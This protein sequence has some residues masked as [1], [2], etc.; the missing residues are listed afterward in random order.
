[1]YQPLA[2]RR[3]VETRLYMG[4][5]THKGCGPPFAPLTDPPDQEDVAG[6]RLRVPRQAPRGRGRADRPPRPV[7]PAGQGT[8]FVTRR[9]M[10]ARGYAL[11]ALQA[12][13]GELGAGHGGRRRAKT[14]QYVTNPAAGFSL[15]FNKYGTVAATPFVP[16]DQR[17][18]GPTGL[19]FRTP[20]L[21][22]PLD[23]VGPIALHLVAK[24]TATRHRL[25]RE[26]LRCR[27]RRQRVADHRGGAARVPPRAR[28]PRARRRGRTTRMWT[29]R[30][31]E[32]ERFYEYDVEIWPTAYRL[33]K[34]HRLQLRLTSPDL[35]T[36]L[37]G[38]DRLRPR[39][40]RRTHASTSSRRRPTPCV[41]RQLSHR[42][43]RG[44]IVGGGFGT[45][46]PVAAVAGRSAQR[47]A[48]PRGIHT[49]APAAPTRAFATAR[50][51]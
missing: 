27:A 11:R 6:G 42:V 21:E 22:R 50:A 16:A 14:R 49:T 33:A 46:L 36:H 37:P 5:C 26:A 51:A 44:R 12:R 34:G 25:V 7:L 13:P 4:P 31:I 19:T 43:R 15:A 17:L 18:E 20:L 8:Q 47:G 10:A 32:P 38:L 35:P 41:S 28:P 1:M 9:P 30:P 45:T 39:P 23:L 48:H 24:S 3:G 2:R 29:R 40:A